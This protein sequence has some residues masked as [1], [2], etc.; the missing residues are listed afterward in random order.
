MYYSKERFIE[1]PI[2]IPNVQPATMGPQPRKVPRKRGSLKWRA[3]RIIPVASSSVRN[4]AA[5]ISRN[6]ALREDRE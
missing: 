1:M 3:S 6:S 4:K 2:I 5:N